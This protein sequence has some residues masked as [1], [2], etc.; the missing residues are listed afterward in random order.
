ME[1][2]IGALTALCA[3]LLYDKY[4]NPK[5]KEELTAEEKLRE[6]EISDHFDAI[7]NYTPE[8]AYKKVGK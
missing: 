7:M 1:I 3:V 2:L 5:T 8:Q 6:K 4:K